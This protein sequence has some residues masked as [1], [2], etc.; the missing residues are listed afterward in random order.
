MSEDLF[1]VPMGPVGPWDQLSANEKAWIEFI[2]VI[3]GGR[4]PKPSP[5]RVSAL[6]A[7]LDAG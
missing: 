2:R 3:S 1:T 6:C 7:L 5:A 4:D